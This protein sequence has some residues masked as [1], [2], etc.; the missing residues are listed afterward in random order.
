[1]HVKHNFIH[2]ALFSLFCFM[3]TAC[4]SLQNDEPDEPDVSDSEIIQTLWQESPHANTFVLDPDGNNNE[5]AQCHAPVEWMPS[6]DS[7]PESCFACK[8]ELEDP[9]PLIPEE[10]WQAIPCIVCHKTD[11]KDNILPEYAWL[12]VA[13]IEQYAGVATTT[14]LCEKCHSPV[15]HEGHKLIQVGGAHKDYDCTNCHEVHSTETSCSTPDCHPSLDDPTTQIVG[16]DE[17]HILIACE[18]CHDDSGFAVG[19]EIDTGIWSTFITSAEE[20]LIPNISHSISL[21]VNCSRC[22][23]TDNPW[24]LSDSVEQP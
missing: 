7:L 1:M 13:A 9:P 6:M 16:H 21:E 4:T 24:G 3:L 10:N 15:E 23:F 14:E 18:A 20:E 5:C 22:H 17:D 11:K 19:P 8:F 12:E 2:L